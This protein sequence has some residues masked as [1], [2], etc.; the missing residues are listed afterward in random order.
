MNENE[1]NAPKWW[2]K[3]LSSLPG[4]LENYL[5]G[6]NPDGLTPTTT[7]VNSGGGNTGG[8]TAPPLL[9]QQTA[10]LDNKI[11][12]GALGLILLLVMF[13]VINKSGK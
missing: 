4:L 10:G 11:V 13:T 8:T 7:P 9:E 6:Q 3:L 5:P 1:N 12:Y 2:E